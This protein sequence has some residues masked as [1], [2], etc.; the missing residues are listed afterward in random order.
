MSVATYA[1]NASRRTGGQTLEAVGEFSLPPEGTGQRDFQ[2]LH[3]DFGFPRLTA[4]TVDL[5]LYT[6]LYIDSDRTGSGTATRLVPLRRLTRQRTWPASPVITDRVCGSGDDD[7]ATEGIF[8][9]IVEAVD[10]TWDL[11]PKDANFLCGM[12]FNSVDDECDYYR[13][14]GM[15]VDSVERRV[16]LGPGELLLFDNLAIAHG[17]IG[18]R[19]VKELHQ[20]CIGQLSADR[21]AQ[22]HL[23]DGL[24]AH[25]VRS[26]ST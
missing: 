23:L 1:S 4:D 22:A 20:L 3:I 12:E 17:R 21:A 14:H 7:S 13:R 11:P 15:N 18:R 25:F 8:A 16:I 19:P 5:A 24:A 6:A 2:A 10:G 26:A 9:R